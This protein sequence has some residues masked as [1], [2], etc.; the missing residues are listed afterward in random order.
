VSAERF[1]CNYKSLPNIFQSAVENFQILGT[2]S[3]E[4]YEQEDE[5]Y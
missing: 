5:I 3:Q 4:L 2:T 1:G